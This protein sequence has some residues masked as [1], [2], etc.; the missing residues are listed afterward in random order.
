MSWRTIVA[1]RLRVHVDIGVHADFCIL[2]ELF[3]RAADVAQGLR[4]PCTL[5]LPDGH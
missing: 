1:E 3:D 4:G 2:T 5:L